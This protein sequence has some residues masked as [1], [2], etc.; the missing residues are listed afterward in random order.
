MKGRSGRKSNY[1]EAQEGNLLKLCT[2]WL[3]NNFD[4]FDKET[5]VRVAMTIA[6]KG[7]VQ[8]LEH[9]GSFTFKDLVNNASADSK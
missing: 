5:K 9:S 7:I 6:Q 2:T 8:K 1:Q 4:T 3:C